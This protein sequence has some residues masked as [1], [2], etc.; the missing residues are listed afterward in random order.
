[1]GYVKFRTLA[2]DSVIIMVAS[3]VDAFGLTENVFKFAVFTQVFARAEAKKNKS[4]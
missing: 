4:L 1:M 2:I 3:A